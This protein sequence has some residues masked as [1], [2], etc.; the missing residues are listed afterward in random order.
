MFGDASFSRSQ[1]V[2]DLLDPLPERRTVTCR[3]GR[4]DARQDIPDH[5][6]RQA[7]AVQ[8]LNERDDGYGVGAVFA[9]SVG[10]SLTAQEALV[11]VIPQGTCA[12]AGRHA[13]LADLHSRSNLDIDTYVNL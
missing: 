6:G 8:V 13:Q 10:S 5:L 4:L 12:D 9:V 11:F 7:R 1:V 2:A 3:P